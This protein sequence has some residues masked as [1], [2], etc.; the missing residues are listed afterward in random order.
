V[1]AALYED[2]IEVEPPAVEHPDRLL[3]R[4]AEREDLKTGAA[5]VFAGDAAHTYR[6]LILAV[7]GEAARIAEPAAPRLAG[8]IARLATEAARAGQRPPPH[9]IRPLYVRRPDAGAA[10]D[11]RPVS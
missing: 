1:Y 11:A 10:S 3:E 2:G 4:Y 9:A 5:I 6:N 7:L 8:T